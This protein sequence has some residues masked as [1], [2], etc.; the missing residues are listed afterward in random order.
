MVG[1]REAC[2]WDPGHGEGGRGGREGAGRGEAEPCPAAAGWGARL[3]PGLFSETRGL[4][5][6]PGSSLLLEPNTYILP[7]DGQHKISARSAPGSPVDLGPTGMLDSDPGSITSQYQ[8]H[9][10]LSSCSTSEAML[11]CV[12][13]ETG[14]VCGRSAGGH[15]SRE[16]KPEHIYSLDLSLVYSCLLSLIHI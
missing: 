3:S 16:K 15:L 7:R 14:F 12:Q 2:S 1:R 9:G 5:L 13:R 10:V 4:K 11:G 8:S 6:M